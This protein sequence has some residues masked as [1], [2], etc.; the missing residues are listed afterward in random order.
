MGVDSVFLDT[1]AEQEVQQEKDSHTWELHA[2]IGLTSASQVLLCNYSREVN[3]QLNF[4]LN[5]QLTF[6][7][8][9]LNNPTDQV[10]LPNY[11]SA[12]AAMG[13]FVSLV[14]K[15]LEGEVGPKEEENL[16][17]LPVLQQTEANEDAHCLYFT[18]CPGVVPLNSFKESRFLNH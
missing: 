11:L 18:N 14:C 4:T 13:I 5:V 17:S 6:Q 10:V 12:P 8:Y 3:G 9:I 1:E 16:L 15:T 2:R 7:L